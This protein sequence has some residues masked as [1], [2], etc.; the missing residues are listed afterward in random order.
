MS[1]LEGPLELRSGW[2]TSALSGRIA[3]HVIRPKLLGKAIY[4]QSERKILEGKKA[5]SNR[6]DQ[7]MVFIL[8]LPKL[9]PINR[10]VGALLPWRGVWLKQSKQTI[11]INKFSRH[12]MASFN[13][14][15][16]DLEKGW[17]H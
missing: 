15:L 16:N 4:D 6:G 7:D 8:P 11:R 5:D 9:I 12:D 14:V 10:A 2:L 1:F 17:P 13:K 3:G